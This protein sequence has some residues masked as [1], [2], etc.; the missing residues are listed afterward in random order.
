MDVVEQS[1]IHRM[2][3]KINLSQIYRN[4]SGP[5]MVKISLFLT[6][7]NAQVPVSIRT[8]KGLWA[9]I[10]TG[11]VQTVEV[12][13]C[14]VQHLEIGG[15]CYFKI[16]VVADGHDFDLC[17]GNLHEIE[18]FHHVH[19]ISITA[20]YETNFCFA[21]QGYVVNPTYQINGRLLEVGKTFVVSSCSCNPKFLAPC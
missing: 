21:S 16:H 8:E 17:E 12:A 14:R 15:A 19:S 11:P 10:L 6:A 20:A 5:E 18:C 2:F 13:G 3:P 9:F 4:L 1:L 7:F